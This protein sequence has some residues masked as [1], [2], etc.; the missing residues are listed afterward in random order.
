MYIHPI[1]NPRGAECWDGEVHEVPHSEE[2]LNV[3]YMRGW[4]GRKM[5]ASFDGRTSRI[6]DGRVVCF[7]SSYRLG[8]HCAWV[9][10]VTDR[11]IEC[12]QKSIL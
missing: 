12:V 3:D 2:V 6:V 10:P 8:L 1:S 7:P 4:L 5:G 9:E 11:D